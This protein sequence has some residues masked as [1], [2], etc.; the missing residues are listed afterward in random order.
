MFLH[1]VDRLEF[2]IWLKNLSS[3]IVVTNLGEVELKSRP[4][5]IKRWSNKGGVLLVSDKTFASIFLKN[6][7]LQRP[8]NPDVLILDEAHT[9]LKKSTNQVYQALSAV[10]TRRKIGKCRFVSRLLFPFTISSSLTCCCNN[11]LI[12][13]TDWVTFSKQCKGTLGCF[14]IGFAL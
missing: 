12:R 10:T 5:A 6:K 1:F 8:F 2:D 7:D 4:L 11:P 14:L 3:S 9:M 13:S